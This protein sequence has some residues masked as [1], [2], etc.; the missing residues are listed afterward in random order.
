MFRSLASLVTGALSLV[1]W[2]LCCSK[3]PKPV[4]IR[5]LDTY[6]DLREVELRLGGNTTAAQMERGAVLKKRG[7][8]LEGFMKE[9]NEIMS[10]PA[11]WVPFQKAVV[12]R[13]DTLVTVKKGAE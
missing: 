7:Y 13:I 12:E 3:E 6:I 9:A 10:D 5:F 1:E 11:R 8:T 4:D 2:L